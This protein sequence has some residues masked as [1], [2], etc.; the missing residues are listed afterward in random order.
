[1]PDYVYRYSA[2]NADDEL[3][4]HKIKVLGVFGIDQI[5]VARCAGS[6]HRQRLLAPGRDGAFVYATPLEASIAYGRD[7]D[8]TE[9]SYRRQLVR[10]ERL[11]DELQQLR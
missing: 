4:L 8:L 2:E 7:L 1:M 10:I 11:R 9:A 5:R 3:V 6:G